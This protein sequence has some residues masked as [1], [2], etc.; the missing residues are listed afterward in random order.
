MERHYGLDWLRIGAFGLLIFYHIGMVFVPWDYHVKTAHP[1]EWVAIP[2]LATNSWRLLLLFVVSGYASRALLM[3]GGGTWAFAGSRSKR[4][5]IPLLFG[6][7]VVIPLQP[8]AELASKYGYSGSLWTFW[9]HDYFRFGKL[10]GI[11]LPTWQH[12]WFVVY[13]WVYT[14]ALAIGAVLIGA[15]LERLKLQ[16]V[17]DRIFGGIGAWLIPAAWLILIAAWLFPG[18][19]ETHAL[20]DDGVAHA[21]Y[22]PGFLFGF[23]LAGS[24]PAFAAIG[25]WWRPAAIVAVASYAVVATIEW[26]WPGSAMPWPFGQVFSWARAIQGWST[27]IA[28]IGFADSHWNRDHRWRATL[29]EAVFP[30]Y[31]IHQTIIVGVEF[32]LLPFHLPPGVEFVILVTTTVAGCWAFYLV[33]REVGWLRPLIGLRARVARP[34]P[35]DTRPAII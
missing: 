24:T 22:L 10:M 15:L 20:F 33:G 1:M 30:F 32:A 31:I 29:T 5:L 34:L 27:I 26:N 28:L 4:L 17:F 8:W 16:V 7:L 13:L 19:R 14:M 3:K 21:Q 2:M 12:L 25:R 35:S 18:A 9:L 6:V 23:A 11:I